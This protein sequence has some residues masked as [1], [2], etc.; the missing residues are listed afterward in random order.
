ML[1]T[2]TVA[3]AIWSAYTGYRTWQ[4]VDLVN[5]RQRVLDDRFVD[6][7]AVACV[8]MGFI[9]NAVVK[10]KSHTL[11]YNSRH[12][13]LY[14]ALLRNRDAV[15]E[16]RKEVASR[17]MATINLPQRFLQRLVLVHVPAPCEHSIDKIA[18]CE[19]ALVKY[20]DIMVRRKKMNS[21][22]RKVL[23]IGGEVKS[24]LVSI[25]TNLDILSDVLHHSDDTPKKLIFTTY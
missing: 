20:D 15:M 16:L 21:E 3:V 22:I 12:D 7:H 23:L 18:A 8:E 11:A 24:R 9:L 6:K 14:E 2:A 25:D 1:S 10:V 17:L 13:E 4:D 5:R 19:A